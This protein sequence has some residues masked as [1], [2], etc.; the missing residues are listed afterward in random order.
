M[1]AGVGLAVPALAL[2][3]LLCL[4][5]AARVAVVGDKAGLCALFFSGHKNSLLTCL[6]MH[7]RYGIL[8]ASAGRESLTVLFFSDIA[9]HASPGGFYRTRLPGFLFCDFWKICTKK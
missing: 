5:A 1:G 2:D 4:A 8:D 6:P 9:P 7:M 3:G